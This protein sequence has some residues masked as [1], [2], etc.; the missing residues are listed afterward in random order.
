MKLENG[1]LFIDIVFI[2]PVSI[3]SPLTNSHEL[4][5]GGIMV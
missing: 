1:E 4:A 3:S 2:I 5:N